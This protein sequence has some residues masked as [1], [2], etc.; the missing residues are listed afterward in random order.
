MYAYRHTG[1][2]VRM[3]DLSKTA[4]FEMTVLPADS[5]TWRLWE[6]VYLRIT[7]RRNQ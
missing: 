4:I 5:D 2:Q 3:A 6:M 7:L 1:T